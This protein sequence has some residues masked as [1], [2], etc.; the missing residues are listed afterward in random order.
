MKKNLM[1]TRILAVFL[2][3]LCLAPRAMSAPSLKALIVTGQNNHNWPVSS[4]VIKIMLEDTGLF[5]VDTA[6]SPKEGQD[7]SGFTPKFADYSVVVLD[8]TGDNWPEAA[9]K[10]FV[11]YVS[12]GGGVVVVHA[13]DNAFPDWP[14]YNE[15]IGLGGWGNRDEKSGP[16]L[17][18]IDG[19]AVQVTEPGPGGGHGKNQPYQII[20][21]A[22]DHP[23]IK[24]L[25]EKWMHGS[26]EL[27]H[28]LRGPGKNL[29]VL[30]T[31][32]SAKEANG[33]G[34]D[35]PLL[36]T[37]QYGKGRVFHTALGHAGDT[38]ENSPALQCAGFITTL[39]RGAEWAATGE[40]TQ[41]VPDDFPAPD[42]VSLRVSYRRATP[43]SLFALLPQIR[44][45]KF[46]DSLEPLV[47]FENACRA[48]TKAGASVAPIED[49]LL[50]VL[51]SGASADAKRWACK[52][53]SLYASDKSL[54]ALAKMFGDRQSADT[55]RLVLQRMPGKAA[56]QVLLE[57]LKT[58]QGPVAAGIA[59]T[60]GARKAAGA[61]PSLALLLANADLGVVIAAAGAL[62]DIGASDPL[63][64]ALS[65]AAP[66]TKAAIEDAL[67]RCAQQL[68]AGNKQEEARH[69]YELLN[70]PDR[71]EA[72]RGAVLEGII[73]TADNKAKWITICLNGDARSKQIALRAVRAAKEPQLLQAI[74]ATEGLDGPTQA[75]L[76]TALA[77]TKDRSLTPALVNAL[78]SKDDEVRS[79]A[80]AALGRI[81]GSEALMPVA[82]MA[83]AC[84]EPVL[85]AARA[86][87]RAM[88]GVA[89][90]I[91]ACIDTAPG[92]VQLELVR[93]AGARGDAG[94]APA[95]IRLAKSGTDEARAAA[96]AA[97]GEA[98]P[99]TALPDMVVLLAAAGNDEA[100]AAA[101]KAVA[102][103]AA[104]A[105]PGEA[106]TGALIDALKK[107]GDPG[108]KAALC[109]AMGAVADDSALAVL[110]E[111]ANSGDG[112][113]AMAAAEAMAAWPTPAPLDQVRALAK[114]ATGDTATAALRGMMRLLGLK[115]D[116]P[117]EE[118][119][120]MYAEAL[121]AV[122]TPEDQATVI[123]G[124]GQTGDAAALPMIYDALNSGQDAVAEA[125]VAAL[126]AWP[127]ATPTEKLAPLA[128]DKNSP[129]QITA[130]R[131]YVR[132]IGLEAARP[133]D[134]TVA[135]Y[136]E[137]MAL[138]ANPDEQK[139]IMS[140]LGRT[141]NVGGLLLAS[142]YLND[143][144]LGEEAAAAVVGIAKS[145]AGTNPEEVKTVMQLVAASSKNESVKQQSGQVMEQA[146]KFEDYLTVWQVSG[147]YTVAGKKGEE[148]FDM[149]F[150]PE[151]EGVPAE[152]KRMPVGTNADMPYVAEID[153]AVGAGND[154]AAYLRSFVHADS[155]TGALLELGSD[156]GAKVWINGQQVFAVNVVRPAKPASDSVKVQLKAG[157]N[158]ILM[159]IT[160][161]A[162]QWAACARLRTA[163]GAGPLTGLKF[164]ATPQK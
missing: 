19:K 140:A 84:G 143:P 70:H 124:L 122:K 75:R 45:Y 135:L 155:D 4:P 160:Q 136:R 98:A 130:L 56:D 163:D 138:A 111:T 162:G 26:D 28:L 159:K 58:A 164:A 20:N 120:G 156:D 8:Y 125:A 83:G 114:S 148:L 21:R 150:A 57:A 73:A 161:S 62:A 59:Q 13:A 23:I 90:D 110:G 50:D 96:L 1:A 87:L 132:L 86:A 82:S 43:D 35:E 74:A 33:T 133:M 97:L 158:T 94:A 129:R 71:S 113:A 123:E 144:N 37:I 127:D 9:R 11:D 41:A 77:D 49:A 52:V 93:A 85:S 80:V 60:L 34:N 5:A 17:R 25:P 126:G 2:T 3:V 65:T 39:Q 104:K 53:L 51:N 151:Q 112:P 118:T 108:E 7:M 18:W 15:I 95:L 107:S 68:A 154:R 29:T 48:T 91:A 32:Y 10:A 142:E 92:A 117:R 103:V 36:F 14:E 101:A 61:A 22:P 38:G 63:V 46:N 119:V 139:R 30:A 157:W 106:R 141:Q 79:A 152:W 54:P 6:I 134:D 69:L 131:G 153:K 31:G 66:E 115:S 100:R 105:E 81:G 44:A 99:P 145:L 47:A 116:R 76:L 78:N 102:A 89:D 149:P 88:P 67:L 55:A 72:V 109:R 27:Y 147:P 24:G 146:A 42:A 64:T 137:A 128:R 121:A 12:N 16:Y 40:V